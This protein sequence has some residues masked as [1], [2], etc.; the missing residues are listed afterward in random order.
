LTSS[1]YL[2]HGF[3]D[4]IGSANFFW[5]FPSKVT[6]DKKNEEEMMSNQL[7]KCNA[8]I[9]E[10]R[11]NLVDEN[12]FR[13]AD[14]RSVKLAHYEELVRQE[15]EYDAVLLAGKANDPKEVNRVLKIAAQNMEHANRWTDNTWT[16][17]KF[18]TSKKGMSGK[19][20]RTLR[21]ISLIAPVKISLKLHLITLIN[22]EQADKMLKIDDAFDYV[23]EAD[24]IKSSKGKKK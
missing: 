4:K 10:L 14:E 13:C 23:T 19:E 9:A 21:Q 2:F 24:L 1:V 5:S 16:V 6:Q 11:N 22:S 20:V 3:S 17:K 8:T 7:A 15:K 12:K 18:L